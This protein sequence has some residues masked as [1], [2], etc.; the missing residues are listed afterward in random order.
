M[1]GVCQIK[2]VSMMKELVLA[3]SNGNTE[4]RARAESQKIVRRSGREAGSVRRKHEETSMVFCD[5][6][7]G[8]RRAIRATGT[9]CIGWWRGGR[10]QQAVAGRREHTR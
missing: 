1:R 4:R 10:E 5:S 6:D 3:T 7:A 2:R 9:G 8:V